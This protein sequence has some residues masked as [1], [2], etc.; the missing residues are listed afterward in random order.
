MTLLYQRIGGREGLARLLRHFYADVR[1]DPLIGPIFNA[2]ITNWSEHLAIIASFW[3]TLLGAARTYSGPMPMMH[4]PL[5]LQPE[6]F[7]RWLFLWQANCRA[8]LPADAA[9]EMISLARHL[10]Q[11]LQTILRTASQSNA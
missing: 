6:H 9:G 10:G 5:G 4:L 11:R 2:Q 8:Q 7:E 3:E 1:Q